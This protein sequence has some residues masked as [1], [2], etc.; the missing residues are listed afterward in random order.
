MS[1]GQIWQRPDGLAWVEV[2]TAAVDPSGW[3]LMIPLVAL[4]DAPDAPPLVIT[5]DGQRARVHLLCGAPNDEL[6]EP[7]G[8]LSPDDVGLLQAAVER[9]VAA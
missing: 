6:G 3:R 7:A 5:V 1:A 9:L 8:Q 4:D 2:Q